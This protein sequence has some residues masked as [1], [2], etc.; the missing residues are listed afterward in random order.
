MEFQTLTGLRFIIC[1][2]LFRFSTLKL[3]RMNRFPSISDAYSS[4]NRTVIHLASL[5]NYAR[6]IIYQD[7]DLISLFHYGTRPERYIL[8]ELQRSNDII[9]SWSIE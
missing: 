4:K 5:T 2:R 9:R 7:L 8:G 6:N 3:S 1:L